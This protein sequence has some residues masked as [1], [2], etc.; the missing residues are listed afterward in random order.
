MKISARFIVRAVVVV[1]LV[2]LLA[3][4]AAPYVD[5]GAFRTRVQAALESSLGRPVHIGDVHYSLFH[6]PGFQV[7]DV[8]IDD[9]PRAGIE[10]FAHVTS[11]KAR[12][13]LASLFG[14]RLAFST[15]RL[16]EPTVNL[17]RPDS[18]SWNIQ[19]F[20][21]RMIAGPG[22]SGESFPDIEV[23]SGRLNFKFGDTKSVFY[24]ADADMDVYSRSS[25]ALIVK[26]E[27]APARTDRGARGFGILSARGT[28]RVGT[29]SENQI[30]MTLEMQRTF[31]TELSHLFGAP[32]SGVHGE[33][34]V[35]A[36]LSGAVTHPS[37]TG[38]LTIEDV[39]RWD[40]S[41]PASGEAW[42]VAW[43]GAV[44]LRSQ[45]IE[46]ETVSPPN[47]TAPPVE[48]KL[49]AS[50]Y[51]SRPKW[52]VTATLHDLPAASLLGTARRMGLPLPEAVTVQGT[53]NGALSYSKEQGL[54]GQLALA[55]ASIAVPTAGSARMEQAQ[56]VVS[57][58]QVAF[59][60][61]TVTLDDGESADILANWDGTAPAVKVDVESRGV[62]IAR[63]RTAAAT[64]LGNGSV[65][66]LDAATGGVLRGTLQYEQKGDDP[67]TWA[68][69]Y[70]VLD[71]Q[72]DVDGLA[73]PL[74][75][76]SAS[77]TTG[78]SELTVTKLRGRAG[79]IEFDADYRDVS[80]VGA[81][82]RLRLAVGDASLDELESLLM[83]S[84]RRPESLLTR[85]R[86]RR[87]IVPAWLKERNMDGTVQ[88]KSLAFGDTALGSVRGRLRWAGTTVAFHDLAWA[89][90]PASGTA[91]MT[92]ALAGP[93]PR[94]HLAGHV[95]DIAWRD[96]D[97]DVEATLDTGGTG[98]DLLANARMDGTFAARDAT[99]APEVTFDEISGS[100][101][102]VAAALPRLTLEKV[103][104]RQERDTLTGQGFSQADGR[105]ALDLTS[106][107]KQIRYVAAGLALASPAVEQR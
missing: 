98:I 100:Y 69:A 12:I 5:A 76:A 67:G 93:V 45:R 36:H 71:T 4:F 87:A 24:I 29:G 30:A 85:L 51:L 16:D 63:L 57:G 28:V 77:I 20:V 6:G 3:G 23:R 52:E 89:L 79:K 83:P 8:L 13:R 66:L 106:G 73:V 78:P 48:V 80:H 54:A 32:D 22:G 62:S 19:P 40:L 96:G 27:G 92:V 43:R 34:T 103:Q 91:E 72:F 64:F 65:P 75:V 105:I 46:M 58:G 2:V 18:D 61:A 81:P 50:D 88:V 53:V 47:Q 84:L 11:L 7:D 95:D 37:V 94:Y 31:I 56:A 14:G 101:H 107:R 59:G 41:S 74:R 82:A 97:L 38:D 33:V 68:G 90:G 21:A 35:A 1:L 26:F 70:N 99:V 9:E 104:A 44:D 49:T 55:D 60:P 17:V 42:T 86:L 39:H 102:F 15:L 25:G 10:P